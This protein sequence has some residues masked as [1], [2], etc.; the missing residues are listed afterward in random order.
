MADLGEHLQH[1]LVGAAMRRA[2]QA[3]DAG[4]DAGERVGPGRAG[5]PNRAG[6]GVLLV[7]RVQDQDQVHRLRQHRIDLVRLG[8]HR[9]EHVQEVLGVTEIVARIYERL[10]DVVLVRPGRDGRHLGDH[11]E[12][13]D[14]PA[15]RIIDVEAVV[16]EGRQRAD[17]AAHHRHRMRVTAEAVVELADL[18]MQ[19]GV[20]HDAQL[21]VLVSAAVGSSPCISR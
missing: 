6:R 3:G 17:H 10:A 2:P 8:R 18:L 5:Q 1:R 16:V 14:L 11:P 12:R 9:V 4:G 21:V 7:V 15:V 13:A 19:H 20:P